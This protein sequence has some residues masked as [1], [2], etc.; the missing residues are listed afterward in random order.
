MQRATQR[1]SASRMSALAGMVDENDGG[2]EVALQVAQAGKQRGDF[3]CGVFAVEA[4]QRAQQAWPDAADGQALPVVGQ[5]KTHSG[6]HVDIEVVGSGGLPRSR[7]MRAASSAANS[8]TRPEAAEKRRRQG[9]PVATAI[10][11]SR[12]DL[13]H[14]GS[15]MPTACSLHSCSTSQRRSCGCSASSAGRRVGKAFMTALPCVC[16][17]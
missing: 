12:K 16:R 14:F 8:R 7:T 10:A 15:P 6:N 3:A 5:V 4:N 1:L 9:V 11:R 13:P 2:F 17:A